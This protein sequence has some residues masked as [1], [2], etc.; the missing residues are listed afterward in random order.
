MGVAY[1]KTCKGVALSRVSLLDKQRYNLEI[2]MKLGFPRSIIGVTWLILSVTSS[3]ARS[4]TGHKSQW[5]QR[6]ISQ[7]QMEP[8]RSPPAKIVHYRHAGKSY[9]YLPPQCCDQFSTLYNSQGRV[10]CAPDGGYSG[11]GDG[12]CPPFVYDLLQACNRGQVIWQDPRQEAMP[13]EGEA[14]SSRGGRLSSGH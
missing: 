10:V 8:M 9:Y 14:E 12:K 6:L 2:F 13:S 7:L 3:S 5:L 11:K 1:R 4:P